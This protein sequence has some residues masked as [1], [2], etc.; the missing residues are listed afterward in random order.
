MSC[1]SAKQITPYNLSPLLKSM[2]TNIYD[3]EE[4]VLKTLQIR[5]ETDGYACIVT[6]P[7]TRCTIEYGQLHQSILGRRVKHAFNSPT[8]ISDP[9]MWT[10]NHPH[11]AL[12]AQW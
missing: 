3:R 9:R 8:H 11:T 7:Y 10:G 5:S 6:R 4:F 12:F 2:N 1:V